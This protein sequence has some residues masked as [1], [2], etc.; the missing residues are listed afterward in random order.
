MPQ[1]E[2]SDQYVQQIV[3]GILHQM[4]DSIDA[5]LV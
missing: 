3:Q 4:S 5:P 2:G 1:K